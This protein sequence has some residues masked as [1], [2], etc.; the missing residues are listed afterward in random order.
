V[1]FES[2][3]RKGYS[4]LRL[5]ENEVRAKIF[6]HPEFAAFNKTNVAI[7]EK[8]KKANLP[9]LNDIEKGARPKEL[10]QKLSESLLSA[11]MKTPLIDAYNMYQHLMDYWAETMQDD[12]YMIVT[13]GWQA[14]AKPRAVTID[15]KGKTTEMPD[16]IAGKLKFKAE[17][18]PIELLTKR[19]FNQEL[20]II[21][22]LESNL[23]STQQ[24]IGEMLEV[25]GGEEGLLS[26]AEE[27]KLSKK[28]AMM[29][30]K[31]I[32]ADADSAEEVKVLSDYL[33][34]IETESEAK[35]KVKEARFQLDEKLSAKYV[36]LEVG[37]IQNLVTYTKWLAAI[38]A[39]L[40][41]ELTSVSQ[42][43]TGRITQ[44]SGRYNTPLSEII[45][46]VSKFSA[47]VEKHLMNMGVTW[48]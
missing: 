24:Q 17:L 29:R 47:K 35:N 10:I 30:L 36:K 38:E 28:D 40:Q 16:F 42:R 5:Q 46:N 18:V 22:E 37:E 33:A 32:M 8:W 1:L 39:G 6:E 12:I 45:S 23:L 3:G 43:L 20:S 9:V 44:L 26:I 2:T 15:A 31:E 48:S 25:E 11:F 34:L 4:K 13:D 7:F 41:S 21:N 14:A 27:G 19:F